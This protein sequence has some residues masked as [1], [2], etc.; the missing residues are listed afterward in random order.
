MSSQR[1]SPYAVLAVAD[2]EEE[3]FREAVATGHMRG[4]EAGTVYRV[5][6]ADAERRLLET[7]RILAVVRSWCG[8]V[9]VGEWD[10][11][12][13]MRAEA[14]RLRALAEDMIRWLKD[15]GHPVKAAEF[16][17]LLHIGDNRP[18]A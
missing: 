2:E 13:A 3:V 15:N 12:A 4:Y 14:A 1:H 10:R 18:P 9:V 17:R 11:V 5:D 7:E 8:S 16:R 6:P